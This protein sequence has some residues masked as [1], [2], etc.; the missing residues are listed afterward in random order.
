M[1]RKI[2][3][4]MLATALVMTACGNSDAQKGNADATSSVEE[5][6]AQESNEESQAESNEESQAESNEESQAESTDGSEAEGYV[7]GVFTETGYESE[8]MGYRF[9]TPEGCTL[10]NQEQLLQMMG[11]SL[12]VL[13]ED[14]SEKMLEYAQQSIVYD[15]FAAYEE[16]NTNINIVLQPMDTTGITIDDVVEASVS[17]LES[18]NSMDITVSDERSTV[19]I[20]GQEYTKLLVDNVANGVTMKQ[21]LYLALLPDKMVNMTVTY[22]EGNEAERDALLAAFAEL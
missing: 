16:T 7:Q 13:S 22:L 21:E 20:A 12:D 19:T 9:T 4:L 8:Y 14:Y 2:A 18:L 15:L 17:Q 3:M 11:L 5:S 6:A 1:K 10:M